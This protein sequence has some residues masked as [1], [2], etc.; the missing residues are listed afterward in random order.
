MKREAGKLTIVLMKRQSMGRIQAY[1]YAW[2]AVM[3]Y[4]LKESEWYKY[5][6][7]RIMHNYPHHTSKCPKKSTSDSLVQ[8]IN[9]KLVRRNHSRRTGVNLGECRHDEAID[10]LVHRLY[11]FVQTE[12]T[13]S[14]R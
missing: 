3:P 14:S 11:M 7:A 8:E 2:R 9:E 6:P 1:R 5:I 10:Q 4:N 12:I 13:R